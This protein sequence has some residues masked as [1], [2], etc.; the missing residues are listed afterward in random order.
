M[1]HD[2]LILAALAAGP[3]S[4]PEIALRVQLPDVVVRHRLAMMHGTRV[5]RDGGAWRLIETSAAVALAYLTT[6]GHAVVTGMR[7]Q[8]AAE[9][10]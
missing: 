2:D 7:A 6:S 3:L 8:L 1:S 10:G 9:G 5:A 4:A